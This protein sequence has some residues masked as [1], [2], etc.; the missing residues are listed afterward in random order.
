MGIQEKP[1]S[2]I[3]QIKKNEKLFPYASKCPVYKKLVGAS[4]LVST[5]S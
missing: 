4:A 5:I 3:L 2:I 1:A